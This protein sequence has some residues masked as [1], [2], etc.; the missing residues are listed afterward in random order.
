MMEGRCAGACGD[1]IS[2]ER[3]AGNKHEREELKESIRGRTRK[4]IPSVGTEGHYTAL[5]FFSRPR[6]D[7]AADGLKSR[8][9]ERENEREKSERYEE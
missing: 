2:Q 1:E 4:S 7:P 5:H 8:W 3:W 6:N 9:K